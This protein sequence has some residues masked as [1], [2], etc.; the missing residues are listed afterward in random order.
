[1]DPVSPPPKIFLFYDPRISRIGKKLLTI[2]SKFLDLYASIYGMYDTALK[3]EFVLLTVWTC[4][5][6][7]KT[8]VITNISHVKQKYNFLSSVH[9][10][11]FFKG[12]NFF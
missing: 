9:C 1:M 6:D 4:K 8:H 11:T 2:C 10:K 7:Q 5:F 12:S 3:I